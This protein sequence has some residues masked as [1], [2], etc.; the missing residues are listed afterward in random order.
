MQ[1]HKWKIIYYV[2]PSGAIPVKEFLD[3]AKPSVK[4]KAFRILFNIREYGLMTA[5][6]HVKKLTG[7][8]LWEIRIVGE[9]SIRILYVTRTQQRILLLHA[10]YKKKQET[11]KKELNT[12]LTRLET[13]EKSY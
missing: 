9:D 5:I 11:S 2:S 4:A 1:A 3:Q 7:T 12:A 6:P 10:F 8:I 13:Y